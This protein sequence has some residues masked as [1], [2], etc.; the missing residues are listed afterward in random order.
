MNNY[1]IINQYPHKHT[2]NANKSSM[3]WI[4]FMILYT[5]SLQFALKR[6]NKSNTNDGN[7]TTYR[8][9]PHSIRISQ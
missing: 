6:V 3:T 7:Y 2:S 5:I 9:P 4:K 8:Y 1:C